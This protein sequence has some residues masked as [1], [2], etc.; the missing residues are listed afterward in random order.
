MLLKG[1]SL[2]LIL[3]KVISL[4]AM[5]LKVMMSKMMMINGGF[6]DCMIGSAKWLVCRSKLSDNESLIKQTQGR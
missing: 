5:Y 3:F 4:K 2:K 6:D 1:V